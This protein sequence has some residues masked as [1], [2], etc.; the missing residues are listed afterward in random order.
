MQYALAAIERGEYVNIFLFDEGL[1]T[2]Y[3]RERGLG[4]NLEQYAR[5]GKALIQ[6]LDPA[7]LSP[8]D[9]IHQI[10]T[11]VLTRDLRVLVIDSL[12]GFLNSMPGEHHLSGQL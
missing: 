3:R 7:E 6:Q 2:L 5:S 11:A 9:F 12:N 4:V 1:T 10:R 8:G